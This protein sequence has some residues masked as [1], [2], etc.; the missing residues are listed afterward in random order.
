MPPQKN[1]ISIA[2]TMKKQ[3][4]RKKERKKEREREGNREREKERENSSFSFMKRLQQDS[5]SCSL[6]LFYPPL[7]SPPLFSLPSL[8]LPHFI[9]SL[10]YISDN[11]RVFL[12]HAL[13]IDHY[14][15]I[16]NSEA[17][18]IQKRIFVR[19][20][21]GELSLCLSLFLSV[22]LSFSLSL[23]LFCFSC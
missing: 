21:V 2:C 4:E 17:T 11:V 18:E 15:Y 12:S 19:E 13:P 1:H 5:M 9:L 10:F 16:L 22:S 23:A 8:L 6:S 3:K 14:R 7:F 20:Q